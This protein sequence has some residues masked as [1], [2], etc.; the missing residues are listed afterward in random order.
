MS[1]PVVVGDSPLTLEDLVAV[2]RH[3]APVVLASGAEDRMSGS[4]AWVEAA[5]EVPEG[6]PSGRLEPVYSINTGFGSLA[7]REAFQRPE[8]ASD[9]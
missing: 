5:M 4:L 3:G 8:M 6:D 1:Q 7:G 9:L 2:A